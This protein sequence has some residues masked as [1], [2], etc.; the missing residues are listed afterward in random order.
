MFES[1]SLE[2]GLF[3]D[4][5]TSIMKCSSFHI[6]KPACD[7]AQKLAIPFL[8]KCENEE[9]LKLPYFTAASGMNFSFFREPFWNLLL[10]M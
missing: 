6:E 3:V 7:R 8:M 9:R 10:W 5:F 1:R 4:G 2:T